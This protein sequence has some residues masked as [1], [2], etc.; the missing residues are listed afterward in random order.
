MRIESRGQLIEAIKSSVE[1]RDLKTE[2]SKK[3][4]ESIIYNNKEDRF[5][6]VSWGEVKSGENNY[7]LWYDENPEIV[8]FDEDT[9]LWLTKEE[10]KESIE[11]RSKSRIGEGITD[12]K[13][14]DVEKGLVFINGLRSDNIDYKNGINKV[15]VIGGRTAQG[16]TNHV[17]EET[18]EAIKKNESVLYFALEDNAQDI[19]RKIARKFIPEVIDKLD[20]KKGVLIT[21]EEKRSFEETLELISSSSLIIDNTH[22]MD[23]NHMIK[24]MEE[25]SKSEKGLDL[26]VIDFLQLAH[27]RSNVN[28]IIALHD[29]METYRKEFGCKVLITTQLARRN[30]VS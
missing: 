21:E 11:N 8:T 29:I 16:K 22:P 30:E 14:G 27:N 23:E 1:T 24:R 18:I 17:I 5:Y 26:V 10:K 9:S 28:G 12:I 7:Y 13:W 19:V 20:R 25:V 4:S 6:R 15:Q 3:T 2:G